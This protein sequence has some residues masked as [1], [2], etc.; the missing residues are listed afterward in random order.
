M[1]LLP[2]LLDC[3]SACC[4]HFVAFNGNK[5]VLMIL[6]PLELKRSSDIYSTLNV[7]VCVCL[8]VWG[9]GGAHRVCESRRA[10]EIVTTP[11]LQAFMAFPQKHS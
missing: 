9:G 5:K 6:T 11:L 3:T 1:P 8:C 4:F 7:R 2:F 10:I